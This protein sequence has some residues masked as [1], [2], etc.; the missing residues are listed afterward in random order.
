M[1][2]LKVILSALVMGILMFVLASCGGAGGVVSS[3]AS[4]VKKGD[5]E[6][7][8]TYVVGKPSLSNPQKDNDKDN[9]YSYI[10]SESAKS[11][12]LKVEESTENKNSEE[13]V[14]SYTIKISY[15][16]KFSG[17]AVALKYGAG[18]LTGSEAT[19][20]TAKKIIKDADEVSGNLTLVV[21]IDND[22]NLLEAASA[23]ALLTAIWA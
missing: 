17:S 16:K 11:F 22:E 18:I 8:A 7:A 9:I 19:K 1:K 23:T 21:V 6:K 14:V 13:K 5:Y 10:Y 2:K 15:T 4:A 20:D 12:K 3:Y